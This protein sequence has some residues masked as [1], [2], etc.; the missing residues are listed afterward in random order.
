MRTQSE[1]LAKINEYKV[2]CQIPDHV[3]SIKC[4][5]DHQKHPELNEA[6]PTTHPPEKMISQ[7]HQQYDPTEKEDDPSKII[8]RPG[9]Y[10][11]ISWEDYTGCC[12]PGEYDADLDAFVEIGAP[13]QHEN[14]G[15]NPKPQAMGHIGLDKDLMLDKIKEMREAVNT[16]YDKNGRVE[17]IVKALKRVEEETLNIAPR[18]SSIKKGLK[19]GKPGIITDVSENNIISKKRRTTKESSEPGGVTEGEQKSNDDNEADLDMV[20][21]RKREIQINDKVKI[22][23]AKF[24]IAYAR[25]RPE[26]TFGK[27]LKINGKQYDVLWE[28]GI[29]MKTHVRHLIYQ[30]GFFKKKRNDEEPRLFDKI[31]RET[32]LPIL[33]VGEALSQP[34]DDSKGSWP[35]DFYEALLRDDWRDWVQAVKNENDSW[36]MFEASTEIP[37]EKMERGASLIPLGELFSIKRSGKHKFRQY[38]L[39]NLLKEGKDFGETF[40]STVSGDGLRWFCSLACSCKK[41][42]RGWDAT[43]GYLQTQ[44]RVNV[45]AF[46]PSHSGYSDPE[47]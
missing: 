37:F 15:E 42:I 5:S 3:L 39:G 11:K 47:L 28:D 17:A 22:K 43:T 32:I 33:S 44:Q 1:N 6:T 34:A 9:E 41:V 35:K 46:L 14:Q 4:L 27:V 24:G 8:R 45:Y 19:K 21:K 18:K 25:G 20:I 29:A 10:D 2:K 40:S 12:K 30:S 38:A 7:L 26:F 16:H 23:T 13:Y 36:S 31:N